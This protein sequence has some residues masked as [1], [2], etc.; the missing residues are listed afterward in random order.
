[1]HYSPINASAAA[2]VCDLFSIHAGYRG[3]EGKGGIGPFVVT[4]GV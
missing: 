4:G 2:P 1:M 3:P